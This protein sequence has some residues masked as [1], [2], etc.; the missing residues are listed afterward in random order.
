MRNHLAVVIALVF[1]APIVAAAQHAPAP[2]VRARLSPAGTASIGQRVLLQ[3]DVIV[4]TWFTTPPEL[5][6][7][8]VDNAFVAALTTSDRVTET[9]GT[10]TW[11]GTRFA[12]AITPQ[13]AGTLKI[14][15]VALTFQYAIDAKPSPPYTGHTRPLELH[16]RLP[17]GAEA[18]GYFFAA[19]S[20]HLSER[21]DPQ[22][23]A[24]L[25]V[26]EVFSRSIALTVDNVNALTLPPVEVARPDGLR[27]TA[28]PPVI[29]TTGEERT[30][31][32]V[33]RTE[34]VTYVAERPGRYTLPAVTVGYWSTTAN[35]VRTA[36]LPPVALEVTDKAAFQE[37][38][39]LPPEPVTAAPP[40]SRWARVR[41]VVRTWWRVALIGLA[42]AVV[43]LM[44]GRRYVPLVRSRL[45]A[46][47]DR[48]AHSEAHYF[49]LVQHAGRD[50]NVRAVYAAA[51]TW[52]AHFPPLQA[53]P[54]IAAL[55][56]AAGDDAARQRLM[57]VSA[58][59]YGRPAA[60]LAAPSASALVADLTSARHALL[61][62]HRSRAQEHELVPLN[63]V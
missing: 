1:A 24:T 47:R 50:G 51:L 12:Y 31:T 9:V 40:P 27:V 45:A 41:A 21:F 38:I 44:L 35:A 54:T 42:A 22:R 32:R 59:L 5:P 49:Q 19:P 3:I 53:T 58:A 18:L 6:P 43:L 28:D 61:H 16:A 25:A 63:P 2:I 48:R 8:D 29:T 39:A 14:P 36:T 57:A 11:G 20:L 15:A 46:D 37:E 7:L 23:P 4:P 13:A 52:L 60:G 17:P 62:R 10:E 33:T 34:H 26:G 30:G 56:A 55:A